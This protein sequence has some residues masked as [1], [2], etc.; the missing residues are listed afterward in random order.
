MEAVKTIFN[1]V[2]L[3]YRKLTFQW[4]YWPKHVAEDNKTIEVNML[5]NM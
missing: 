1:Q 5:N 4:S 2:S 3:F